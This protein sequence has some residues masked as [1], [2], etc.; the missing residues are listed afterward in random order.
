[1]FLAQM[2]DEVSIV[3]KAME[4]F[5]VTPMSKKARINKRN[6][7]RDWRTVGQSARRFFLSELRNARIA[8]QKDSEAFD[9]VLFVLERLGSYRLA[10]IDALGSYEKCICDL[11]R[12][13]SL[14]QSLTSIQAPWHS[15]IEELYK[16]V[17]DARND[18]LHQGA[19]A[20]HLTQ[21]V[22]ELGIVLEDACMNGRDP[23]TKLEDIMVRS[24]VIADEW[25][26]ISFI[27]QL[28]LTNAFT[29][30]PIKNDERWKLIADYH[31]ATFLRRK[32]RSVRLT[33]TVGEAIRLDDGKL[34][35]EDTGS[36]DSQESV[37]NIGKTPFEKPILV[38]M[39]T[40][41]NGCCLV[42]IVTAFD[43]L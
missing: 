9:Q 12:E 41:D 13:S 32:D 6:A 28:M 25:Q 18:A 8:A 42:G 35:L 21:H 19:R 20:R 38:T 22:I 5:S 43:I 15:Q 1:M 37:E 39:N 24:P 2:A 31:L 4:G 17:R 14:G 30:I 26:P 40:K 16:L 27:R 23:L 11:A 7:D 29:F 3:V 33:M 10:E 34:E 36:K